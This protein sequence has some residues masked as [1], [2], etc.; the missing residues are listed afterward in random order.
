MKDL[1]DDLVVVLLF[2]DDAGHIARRLHSPAKSL[3]DAFGLRKIV[4][5]GGGDAVAA[6]GDV[7]ERPAVDDGGG[8]LQRLHQIGP[9]RVLQQRGH[10]AGFAPRKTEHCKIWSLPGSG[11]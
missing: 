5:A 2:V 6:V 11:S 10:G 9:E 8:P 3:A 1:G 4:H 7:G